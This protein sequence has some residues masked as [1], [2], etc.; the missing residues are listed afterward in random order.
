MSN[1]AAKIALLQKAQE[2]AACDVLARGLKG[3]RR[4]VTEKALTDHYFSKL[5]A[6][7]I[8]EAEAF[9]QSERL[10]WARIE[11]AHLFAE[12]GLQA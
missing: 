8:A 11:R 10:A 9:R 4:E 3:M 7:A 5:Q 2:M 1:T 6:E 12:K